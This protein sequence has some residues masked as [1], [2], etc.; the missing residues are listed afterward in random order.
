M[1][2]LK[3]N[4]RMKMVMPRY[5]PTGKVMSKRKKNERSVVA[6]DTKAPTPLNVAINAAGTGLT[7]IWNEEFS[8]P[9]VGTTGLSLAGMTHGTATLSATTSSGKTTTATISRV[10][11]SDEV[12]TLS[13]SP[14]NFT[15]SAYPLPNPVMSFTGK[16]ITNDST[17][18][19]V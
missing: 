18:N 1:P 7:V 6:Y 2:K 11:N 19:F 3:D 8:L 15:D 9:V 16:E 5:V 4:S 14:G 12:L 17:V 10:V 13:Y